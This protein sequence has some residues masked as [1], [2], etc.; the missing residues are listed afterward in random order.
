MEPTAVSR[1]IHSQTGSQ[2]GRALRVNHWAV[3]FSLLAVVLLVFALYR[4][5]SMGV[6]PA[7]PGS[8]FG[9]WLAFGR[10]LSG[11]DVKTARAV[12][13]PVFPA[14]TW[15]TANAIGP[16]NA[17]KVLGNLSGVLLGVPLYLIAAS[18]VPWG[19][20]LLGAAAFVATGY[21]SEVVAFGGYPQLLAEAFALGALW[22]FALGVTQR[23]LAL[24]GMGAIFASLVVGTHHLTTIFLLVA[25]A[26]CA[27][28]LAAQGVRLRDILLM[29][30]WLGLATA[31]LSIP[32]ASTYYTMA[33]ELGGS[34]F[35]VQG[36]TI[37]SA[38]ETFGYVF[39]NSVGLWY[40]L[41]GV[42]AI[43]LLVSGPKPRRTVRAVTVASLAGALVL[44]VTY[45]EVRFL[46]FLFAGITLGVTLTAVQLWE[47]SAQRPT[48]SRILPVVAMLG[49]VAATIW[50]GVLYTRQAFPWYQVVDHRRLEALDWLRANTRED[51]IIATTATRNGYQLGWWVEGYAGRKT[52]SGGDPRWLAYCDEKRQTQF[53]NSIFDLL[54]AGDPQAA[55]LARAAGISYLFID[56][57]Y[58]KLPRVR[59]EWYRVFENDAILILAVPASS[60]PV[61]R[62]DTGPCKP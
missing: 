17:G 18:E 50:G 19:F 30:L 44:F 25:L 34:P 60:V 37:S 46:Q 52:L 42:A 21:H 15:W 12:Y 6:H 8:D 9:N 5:E 51:A 40:A 29:L 49:I 36:W 14:I 38:G 13:P 3:R 28:A 31:L 56:K 35:N 59:G 47:L 39:R 54:K 16:L 62:T 7:P 24:V 53:A 41:L 11:Q 26:I 61:S 48:S 1:D 4:F 2:T 20:A 57:E 58:W 45:R 43:G 55:A 32:Y 22:L 10:Q 33:R 27:V 23:K